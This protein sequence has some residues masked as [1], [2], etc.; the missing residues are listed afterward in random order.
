MMNKKL[1]S[2][3][4][5]LTVAAMMLTSI[6]VSAAGAEENAAAAEAQAQTSEE[7]NP[8]KAAED[9]TFELNGSEIVIVNET[10]T[11]VNSAKAETVSAKAEAGTDADSDNAE[12]G[13]KEGDTCTVVLDT[14]DGEHRFEKV[15][16]LKWTDAKLIEDHGFLYI[17]YTETDGS[18]RDASETKEAVTPKEELIMWALTSVNIREEADADSAALKVAEMGGECKVLEIRPGWYQV[19]YNGVTGYIN[20]KFLSDDK[21]AVDAAVASAK[22]AEAAAAAQSES[23]SYDYSDYDYDYSDDGYDGGSSGG[24]ASDNGASGGDDGSQ[25][26]LTGGLLN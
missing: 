16:P 9:I 24:G 23:Y 2:L 17:R 6:P 8:E 26:C 10:E 5:G 18:S 19:E 1:I 15:N 13:T 14:A 20:H 12:A 21:E 3:Y 11:E 7:A 22:A 4:L 25:G